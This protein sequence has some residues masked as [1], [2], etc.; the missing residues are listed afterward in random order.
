M[1][2]IAEDVYEYTEQLAEEVGCDTV[3]FSL[4]EGVVEF[5]FMWEDDDREILQQLESVRE[6]IEHKLP[7]HE[8]IDNVSMSIHEN[9]TVTVGYSFEDDEVDDETEEGSQEA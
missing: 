5:R 8:G 3:N 7:D 4:W 2:E 1:Q 9:C 6:T